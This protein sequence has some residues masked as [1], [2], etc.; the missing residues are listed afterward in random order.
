M[1]YGLTVHNVVGLRYVDA[2]G[3]LVQLGGSFWGTGGEPDLLAVMH[4][5]EGMLGIVTEVTVRLLPTPE[6]KAVL[7]AS[8]V[9]V[10]AAANAV[11]RVIAAGIIPAGL[12]M[13]DRLAVRAAE[14]FV[15][16]GYPTDCAAILLCELD[17]TER[18]VDALVD[19][20]GGIFRDSGADA[21]RASTDPEE[22]ARMWLGR[23]AAFPAVGRLAPDYY[24][25]D[26]TIPRRKP[27]GSVEHDQYV[28]P[29]STSCR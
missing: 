4:G 26:G 5:S 18:E 1:K 7:L 21:L 27:C 15:H 9:T 10:E 24:C 16:A 6:C 8:F 19:E 17:G 22:Q 29:P 14:D 2:A 3:E 12:E 20:V 25:M 13:M 11:S 23:K 28:V